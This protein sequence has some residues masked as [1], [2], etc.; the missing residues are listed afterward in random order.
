MSKFN[1]SL[2]NK[3]MWKQ[4]YVV[5]PDKVSYRRPKNKA[6]WLNVYYYTNK[7]ARALIHSSN[8][9]RKNSLY[10]LTQMS[11]RDKLFDYYKILKPVY[12]DHNEVAVYKRKKIDL[13]KAY[14]VV[15]KWQPPVQ[16]PKKFVVNFD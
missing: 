2:Y 11:R 7:R 15:K 9:F 4:L 10:Y 14:S 12:N 13:S 1:I 8:Y 5:R 6:E 3:K 16:K